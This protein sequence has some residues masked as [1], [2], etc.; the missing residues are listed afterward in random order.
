MLTAS[1]QV[2]LNSSDHLQI[3]DEQIPNVFCWTKMGT[4][5]GQSLEKILFRKELERRAGNG[6]FAWGIGSSLGE[7]A[8]LARQE[9][10][11][12]DVLFSPMKS[13]AKILDAEPSQ[14]LLWLDYFDD[15]AGQI[16]LP[17]H[18]IITSRGNL[19]KA[20]NKRSHYALICNACDDITI[21]T[22][23][24]VINA[25]QARNF[26]S[27]NPLGASQVTALVRYQTHRTDLN[28]KLYPV[29]FRATLHGAGF[30]RLVSPVVLGGELGF[31]YREL[32]KAT[33]VKE[34]TAGAKLLRK[35][36]EE[37]RTRQP[38]Q[39]ELFTGAKFGETVSI[40]HM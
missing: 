10:G 40:I 21:P 14:V 8:K 1:S 16:S 9:H 36:A 35:K 38:V 23:A 3:Q 27:L 20:G 11:N 30:V 37:T 28:E 29:T 32:C 18:M 39:R 24:G 19:A 4:E 33:T 5:A 31:L 15:E 17:E 26:A 7:G 6:T 2:K 34:W 25:N 13:A 22:A 12:I